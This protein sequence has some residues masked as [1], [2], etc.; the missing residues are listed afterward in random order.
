MYAIFHFLKNVLSRLSVG[1]KSKRR[2]RGL[3]KI[4]LHII[5]MDSKQTFIDDVVM[6]GRLVRIKFGG[7]R[8]FKGSLL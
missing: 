1:G 6:N 8:S 5:K 4:H 2:A 3:L 7:D